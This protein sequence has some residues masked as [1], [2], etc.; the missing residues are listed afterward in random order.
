MFEV[1]TIKKTEKARDLV[2]M[3]AL[4]SFK[5]I[6]VVVLVLLSVHCWQTVDGT[7]TYILNDLAGLGRIFDGIGGLSGGG[8][9]YSH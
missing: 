9:N 4:C 8:V 2:I 7:G 6:L 1:C 5:N 3:A